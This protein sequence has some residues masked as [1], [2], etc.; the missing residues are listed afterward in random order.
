MESYSIPR[1]VIIQPDI[2]EFNLVGL[3]VVRNTKAL[4]GANEAVPLFLVRG[5]LDCKIMQ[6]KAISW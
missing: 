4:F 2:E 1:L 6:A 3:E 5:T